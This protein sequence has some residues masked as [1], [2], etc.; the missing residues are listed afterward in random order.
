MKCKNCDKENHEGSKFCRFCGERMSSTKHVKI[1]ISRPSIVIIITVIVLGGGSVYAAPKAQDYFSVKNSI[2]QISDLE[3]KGEY[4]KALDILLATENKWTTSST[5][6]EI[7]TLKQ[8][9]QKYISWKNDYNLALDN[10]AS[11]SYESAHTLL[12][13]ID[14]SYPQYKL[15]KDKLTEVQKGIQDQ[16]NEK[17]RVA[18]QRA[19]EQK[20][21]AASA[22]QQ[23]QTAQQQAREAANSSARA[24][25]AAR[26]AEIDKSFRNQLYAAFTSLKNG[27]S[28][29]NQAMKYKNNDETA[30]ALIYFAKAN[31]V[32]AEV[33]TTANNIN[34]SFTGMDQS[35]V[36]AANNLAASA[37]NNIKAANSAIDGLGGTGSSS[38]TN[39]YSN[40]GDEYRNSVAAF[41]ASV[42]N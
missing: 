1:P 8:R 18:E 26:S 17:V 40:L 7:V 14:P 2:A 12:E 5:R 6:G 32:Y 11:S 23:A 31:T 29:Y 27:D 39:Y 36:N 25:T 19:S 16:L 4:Q 3:L 35:Y 33:Q 30:L 34:S 9:E 20:A 37:S 15:V 22:R 13:G 41:F 21:A 24:A 38:T 10:M 42:T 28:Y